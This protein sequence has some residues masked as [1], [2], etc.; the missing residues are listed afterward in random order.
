SEGI[1]KPPS[2]EFKKTR[3]TFVFTPRPGG[4]R[5]DPSNREIYERAMALVSCVRKGQ[6]LAEQ[7]RIKMPVRILEVL[8]EKGHIGS[9]SEAINQYRNLVFLR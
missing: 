3:E 1:L 9:N 8:R 4:S 5:M 2:I 7:Y 6:L